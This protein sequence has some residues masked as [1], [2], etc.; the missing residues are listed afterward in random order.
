MKLRLL[1][2][3]ELVVG[4]RSVNIGG[5]RQRVVLA[6]L[7]LN[8]NRVTPIDSLVDALWDEEPPSTARAQIQTC[9]YGLRKLFA[10]D[11]GLSAAIQTKPPGYL[12][13]MPA[14]D[15]DSQE[16]TALVAEGRA[17]A[18]KEL[19]E[20]AAGTLRAALALWRGPMLADINSDLVQRGA[21]LFEDGRVAAIEEWV[22]LDLALGRHE[23]VISELAALVEEH[24]Y[25][26]RLAELRMIALY[27]CGRQAD[28]LDAARRTRAVLSDELGIEP[29][30]DL[31]KLE[32]AILNRDPSLDF[33]PRAPAAAKVVP[34]QLP[35]EGA[36]RALADRVPVPRQLPASIADFTG[37]EEQI[38][39]IKATIAPE[40]DQGAY[41]VRIVGISG[42]GGVG[43]SSLAVRVAHE[44]REQ[45]PDGQ[46]Y[47]DLQNH[48]GMDD[49][50]AALLARFLRS[51][52]VNGAAVP[53]DTQE[54]AEMYRSLLA[55]KRVLV[56]L[57]DVTSEAEV[58]PLLPGSATCAVIA[59]SRMRLPGLFGAQWF[60]IDVLDTAAS[61]GLLAKIIGPW[62]VAAETDSAEELVALCGGLPLAL[63]IAGA[64]LESR[65]HWRVAALVARLQDE[66]GR[67]DEFTYRG[68]GLRFNIDLTYRGLPERAKR[69]LRLFAV[70]R[71]ADFPA[72]MAAALLDTHLLDAEDVLEQLVEAQL[73]DVVDFPGERLRYRFHSLIRIYAV[74]QVTATESVDERS[75]ALERVVGGWLALAENAHRDEYGGDYTVL[76]GTAPR[77]RAPDRVRRN[78]STNPMAWWDSERAGLVDAVRQ[79]ATAGLDELCWD[80]ALTSITLFEVKGYYDYWRETATLGLD[81]TRRADNRRGYAAMLYSLGTLNLAQKRLADA[82]KCF[83]EALEI[84]SEVGDGHGRALVLRNSAIIDNLHGDSATMLEKY[85]ES[86]A[87]LRECGDLMGEAQV[88]RSVAEFR[89]NEGD[90]ALAAELLD[91][92]LSICREVGCLRGEAQVLYRFANL[93]LES[94]AVVD[95]QRDLSRVRDIVHQIGDRM[96]EAYAQ[97]GLGVALYRE[98][99]LEEAETELHVALDLALLLGERLVEGQSLYVLGEISLGRDDYETGALH[100]DAAGVVFEDLGS[101]LW[102]AKTLILQSGMYAGM[103]EPVVAGERVDH[104][105]SL[106]RGLDSQEA[107]R[108]LSQFDAG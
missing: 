66:V 83:A 61:T 96:G 92:A 87:L 97:Y 10:H 51:L 105:R 19:H 98:G 71:A 86:L 28:A 2:P 36:Q 44:L 49:P 63:R 37:R 22:R 4:R 72:W 14:S 74:E 6:M 12:L 27:R 54:R 53:E 34:A 65:P 57:D 79:A 21:A 15:L 102:Q 18:G 20:D 26:E 13:A 42:K 5:P 16:F 93:R 56:V 25:N 104:A 95:A 60:D 70:V 35:S 24:P 84:F 88:L 62:R 81:V 82:G 58:V 40:G 99:R 80:L 91:S 55:D 47:G 46:L 90:G 17:Q 39:A 31:H 48:S 106:L 94:G 43:K 45:F 67:L 7:A 89:G 52:G 75:A 78:R 73:L 68:Y 77:W 23:T 8:V 29:G 108:L 107:T 41:A 64:R 38:E 101:A 50:S 103:G 33:T 11:A 76:H 32:T 59:T 9:I 69:L 85:T 30:H 1:G 3:L 100:L